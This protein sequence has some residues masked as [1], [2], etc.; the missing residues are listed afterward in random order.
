[1]VKYNITI[2][3]VAISA[4]DDSPHSCVSTKEIEGI[5]NY[6]ADTINK[7]RNNDEISFTEAISDS[8][9]VEEGKEILVKYFSPCNHQLEYID[10]ELTSNWID[11]RVHGH[12]DMKEGE[13]FNIPLGIAMKLPEGYEAILAPR[14]S[15]FKNYGLIQANSIGVFDESYCGDDDQWYFPAYATRD[16]HIAD[17]TRICQFRI[18]KHQPR[19]KFQKVRKLKDP[20]RGGF[21]TTGTN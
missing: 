3:D 14:S 6:A 4:E 13:Y 18:V 9:F 7:I 1:M 19:V 16:T 12:F 20:N 11:L 17:G 8:V 5:L 2:G 15:T 21:G 10:G